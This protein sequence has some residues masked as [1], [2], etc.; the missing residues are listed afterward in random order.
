MQRL[1]ETFQRMKTFAHVRVRF[2]C[3]LF[4]SIV[5]CHRYSSSFRVGVDVFK[6]Q[7]TIEQKKKTNQIKTD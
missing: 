7:F 1:K 5:K 6:S 3:T 2:Q 4:I